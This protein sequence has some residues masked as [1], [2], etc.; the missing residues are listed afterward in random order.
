MGNAYSA[1]GRGAQKL[2]E[3]GGQAKYLVMTD[4]HSFAMGLLV[5]TK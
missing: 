5:R 3:G 2:C 1:S 4:I